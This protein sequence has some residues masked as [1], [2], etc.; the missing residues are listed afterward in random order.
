MRDR[1]LDDILGLP[2]QADVPFG[3][4]MPRRVNNLLLVTSLYD[5]YTFIEDGRLSEMLLSEYEELNLR[6]APS[7]ERVSTAQEALQRLRSEPF[8]L[9]ISMP[10]VGEMDVRDFGNAVREIV[11][12]LPIILLASSAR[13]LAVLQPLDCIPVGDRVFVWH[14][15]SR[16]FLAIIKLTEDCANAWHDARTAGVKSIILIEDSVHFY[17]LY[18]PILY[19]EIMKQTQG[20]MAEGVNRMQRVMRMRA[21]PKILLATCYE[22]ALSLYERYRKDLLGVILDAFFPR[23]G[24]V[25]RSAGLDFARMVRQETPGIPMLMQSNSANAAIADSLGV[26][27]LNKNSPSLLLELR[28]FMQAHLGFGEFIFRMPGGELVS[29][30]GD[31]RSLEWALRAIPDDCLMY[32]VGRGDFSTWLMA[33]TEFELAETVSQIAKGHCESC[34]D[35]RGLMLQALAAHRA[36]SRAGVVVDFSHR[37]FEGKSGFVRIGTGSLG[38]KGRGL[39]FINS[40]FNT[41]KIEGRI[42]GV[43]IFIPPT[44]VLSTGVFEQYMESSGLL[45]FALQETDDREI[46]R[47]FLE[48]DLPDDVVEN[49]W[50]F[51]DWV[52]YPLAVRSSSLLEDASFQPFAGIY[53][54][55][56]IPNNH[57][58]PEVRLEELSKAIRMVYASTYH[59]DA[60]AYIESTPNRLEEEKMAVVIQQVVGKPH[61][62]YFYPN[63]AGVA[64]SLN[65][66]PMPG[67]KPE[68]GVASVVLGLGKGVVE[69]DRCVRFSPAYPRKPIQSLTTKECLD[70]AQRAFWALELTA[71]AGQSDLA[72]SLEHA[73]QVSLDLELAEK[74]GTL[75]PVASVYSADNDAIYDGTSR[76]GIRLVSMAGVLKGSVF[77][78]AEILSLSLKVGAAASSCPIEMEFAVNLSDSSD[79]PHEFGFLQI[80]PLALGADF[81]DFQLEQIR[82]EDALCVARRAL[83]NGLISG[84]CDLIYVR[85]DRFARSKTKEIAR[86][87][88]DLNARLREG[89]RPFLLIGPGRWGSADPW[90]GIPV[91]WAQ[92]SGVRCII[93]TDLEDMHVD[94][95]QGS[96]FLH[97]IISFGIGYLTVDMEGGDRL[98]YGLLDTAPAA[99]ETQHVRLL[100]FREPLEIALNGRRNYGVVMNPGKQAVVR[101][102]A[103]RQPA[104]AE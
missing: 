6:F 94:P 14:G 73:G 25:D 12:D 24:K 47:A 18:L 93:E 66:Y 67:M 46:T 57:E 2:D 19:T 31:L 56:M 38:G 49:L 7:I 75:A 72:R 43:R 90:L 32:H 70:N 1:A 44:A 101:E 33:R 22:E 29:R 77:P 50:A 95:S 88:G 103:S 78:L 13:E 8:D 39:A 65:F 84:V 100:S 83:G 3:S 4:L 52:R 61:D 102:P 27:F 82:P 42:P 91:K 45:S 62:R 71:S 10:R 9:V 48:A 98:D 58:D 79:T 85:R 86:E 104:P 30:A 69:G 51:L 68:D 53:Q 63:L 16:L 76:P 97:N 37:S 87:I 35:V 55:Y 54:T 34:E 99:A 74:H 17:S 5:S 41:Y 15:D 36:R 64:R 80:R 92:I 23:A 40:L 20:L 21:R 81:R 59:A 60:K 89:R 96:H 11:P 28:E 26:E